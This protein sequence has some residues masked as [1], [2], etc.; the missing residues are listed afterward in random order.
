MKKIERQVGY[1]HLEK[2]FV[3]YYV[4]KRG[5]IKIENITKTQRDALKKLKLKKIPYYKNKKS[6]V[7]SDGIVLKKKVQSKIDRLL[8]KSKIKE[9]TEMDRMYLEHAYGQSYRREDIEKELKELYG[10]QVK[11]KDT[12]SL[13]T[14]DDVLAWH[15][16]GSRGFFRLTQYDYNTLR[17]LVESK[18]K[19]RRY[20][21]T[22]QISRG[23]IVSEMS[24]SDIEKYDRFVEKV[25]EGIFRS[26][27]KYPMT[28][29]FVKIVVKKVL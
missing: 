21:V 19:G 26:V 22:I 27:P 11:D 18:L 17:A 13:F 25:G 2:K 16:R 12:E 29:E 3:T 23:T 14:L 1:D 6:D 24:F 7:S 20:Q 9:L 10:K 8:K 5:K 4:G 15:A 28:K